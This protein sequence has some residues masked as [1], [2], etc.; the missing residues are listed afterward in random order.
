MR[1]ANIKFL[2]EVSSPEGDVKFS[3]CDFNATWNFF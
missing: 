1:E 2:K 3:I